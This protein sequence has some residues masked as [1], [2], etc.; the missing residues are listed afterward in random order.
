MTVKVITTP[1][2]ISIYDEYSGTNLGILIKFLLC[3]SQWI[4]ERHVVVIASSTYASKTVRGC[5]N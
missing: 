3:S 4:Q 2:H 5:K 1:I